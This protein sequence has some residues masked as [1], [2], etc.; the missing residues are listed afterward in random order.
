LIGKR[1][2]LRTCGCCSDSDRAATFRLENLQEF[3]IAHKIRLII[4]DSIGSIIRKD[5]PTMNDELR[6][7]SNDVRP[8]LVERNDLLVREA[9]ALK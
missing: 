1:A 3:I 2:V 6:R 8:I 7:N 5:F 9:A 4:V